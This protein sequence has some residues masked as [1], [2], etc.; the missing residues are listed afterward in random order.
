MPLL[1]TLRVKIL[2]PARDPMSPDTRRHIA[3][4]AFFAWVGLGADGLSSSCYGP[5]EAFLALG[6][7]THLAL[8]LAIAT[9]ITVFI[10]SFA[11]NQVIELFP[12]G[13]GGY[14]VA[15]KLIGPYAG[16]VSGA[17]LIVDYVLT[18]AISVASG[19]D[20]LFSLLPVS[21]QPFKLATSLGFVL[22]LVILNLR[23]MKES[24]KFLLPIFVGF[25]L[26]H[27]VLIVYGIFFHSARLPTLLHDTT[28]ETFNLSSQLGWAFVISH[29]L[30]AYSTGGGTYT[31]L[32]AVSNNVN[33][34]AEPRART[35]KWTMFY[36]AVSLAFTASGIIMLYLL[37]DV[38]H[39]PGQTLNAVV[40]NDILKSWTLGGID[41]SGIGLPVVLALEAGLL[42]VA[43]NTGFLGGPAVLANMAADRWVPH[44]FSYL[45]SRLVTRNGVMLMAL[46]AIGILLW[47]HGSVT[48]LVVLYGVNVFLTFSLS[49]AGMS[50]YWWRNRGVEQHWVWHLALSGVGLAVTAGI[51]VVLIVE[52]F[53]QGGWVTVLITS[54][55]IAACLLVRR[56]YDETR[57]QLKQIDTLFAGQEASAV[58]NPPALD[59]SLPTAVLLVGKSRGS[60]MHTLLWV[61]RLFPEHFKNFIFVS[62]GEVDSQSYGGSGAL[63][64]L[65][66]EVGDNLQYFINFCHHNGLAAE[67]RLA[68]G[69]DVALELTKLAETIHGEYDNCVFFASKLIFVHD[70]W[71]TRLLHNQ[72]ADVLQRRLH[73]QGMQMVILP[74]K[75]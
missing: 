59:H 47:S 69:S 70:N 44:Q 9:A 37:W 41:W 22:L 56:H 20:A 27:L 39:V 29:L 15:T 45:S 60:G 62:V 12:S 52:K 14:K 40:F 42:F 75:V 21:A 61:Q 53:G 2:G 28:Q 1:Q 19:A 36:L 17:A 72:T 66:D 48:L 35:G 10:I 30:L 57:S 34:L 16:L 13:G 73:L 55:V 31:G 63:E 74:M 68:Y 8:Y 46:A 50:I 32:E 58:A 6:Q 7:H 24:I 3:L 5:E 25:V 43:A 71:G 54:M 64:H 65:R 11:Y 23:G 38:H 4:I 33:T 51:L 18:I 49:L 26:T 67:A